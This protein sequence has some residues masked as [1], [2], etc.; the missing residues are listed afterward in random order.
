MAGSID[1][2]PVVVPRC[3]KITHVGVQPP[4]QPRRLAERRRHISGNTLPARPAEHPVG[5]FHMRYNTPGQFPRRCRGVQ[6]PLCISDRIQRWRRAVVCPRRDRP[7]HQRQCDRLTEISPLRLTFTSQAPEPQQMDGYPQPAWI[8]PAPD[9]RSAPAS[10]ATPWTPSFVNNPQLPQALPASSSA[11]AE[12]PS[13]ALQSRNS[14]AQR[15]PLEQPKT[16]VEAHH[17]CGP[18][19]QAN[20][21]HGR[22]S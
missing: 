17:L 3:P 15:Q 7:W 14:Q 2:Q 10:C 9:P 22:P 12:S 6:P 1:R 20:A 4:G 21:R 16:P 18:R 8:S 13:K 19:T 11:P 5:H